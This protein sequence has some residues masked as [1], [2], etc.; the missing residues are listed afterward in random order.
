MKFSYK[1]VCFLSLFVSLNLSAFKIKSHVWVGQQVINDLE[2]DYKLTFIVDG[3]EIKIPIRES[4]RDAILSNKND[5]LMGNIG[6]DAIPDVVVGQ[7]SVHPGS[8]YYW[9]TNDW[10]KYLLDN[11]S[12][13]SEKAFVYGYLGHIASDVFAHTYVNQYAGDVF[14]LTD[15][16]VV[17]KRHFILESFI[18]KYLPP[19]KD[20][21]NNELGKPFEFISMSDENA[22]FIR[23]ELIFND[24]VQYQYWKNSYSRHLAAFYELRKSI[25]SVAEDGIWHDIDVFVTQI[26]AAYFNIDLTDEE[27]SII[28]DAANDVIDFVNNEITDEL[29]VV[30]NNLYEVANKYESMGFNE[31]V[32]TVGKINALENRLLSKKHEIESQVL[33]LGSRLNNQSCSLLGDAIEDP[34]GVLD[35]FD[36]ADPAGVVEFI[37]DN[38]PV[39]SILSGIFNSNDNPPQPYVVWSASGTKQ[40]FEQLIDGYTNFYQWRIETRCGDPQFRQDCEAATEAKRIVDFLTPL[41]SELDSDDYV[42]IEKWSNGWGASRYANGNG[43]LCDA[44]NNIT[45]SL[46]RN[47]LESIQLVEQE[48]LEEKSE[49]V[50]EVASIRQ[51]MLAALDAIRNMENAII[52]LSQMISADVNP[53][54][55]TL[56]GWRD[57]IDFSMKEYVKATSQMMLNTMDSNSSSVSPLI[58]WFDCYHLSIIGVPRSISD[59]NFRSSL[60]TVKSSLENIQEILANASI[61]PGLDDAKRE[62]DELVNN[63]VDEMTAEL[64]NEVSES[65]QD[66]LPTN[67]RELIELLDV[68]VSD[69]VLKHYFTIESAESRS[70]NLLLIDD[71]AQR[72]K[73]EMKITNGTLNPEAFAPLKNSIILAKLALL[74]SNDLVLFADEIGVNN[75]KFYFTDN[76]VSE[77]FENID[78]NH[79]WMPLSPPLPNRVGFP[80]RGEGR[81]YDTDKGFLL[82]KDEFRDEIFRAIFVG[83]LSPGIDYPQMI[84]MPKILPDDYPYKP[85]ETN[86]YPDSDKDGACEVIWLIPI[87]HLLNN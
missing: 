10:T 75:A 86:P 11:A 83:P 82:W 27:A 78:G 44:L 9:K 1:F 79:Q 28:V 14:D 77:S 50:S 57:D 37:I 23:D 61:P 25:D 29:Q 49:L 39:I 16:T 65:V 70:K 66:I 73:S 31:V 87:L 21:Q 8:E 30:L 7:T 47:T 62:L 45:D 69:D 6:P 55:S 63:L 64:K 56:R 52:D 19:F 74:D 58:E 2:D 36:I 3:K 12:S 51:E 13:P 80:Y 59:C 18:D 26:V 22:L 81:S 34:L 76:L 46:L 40:S 35:P 71:V 85:C 43:F 54:Q 32:S 42:T 33:N 5:F 48:F 38:D 17:E 15:E 24:T 84:N 60:E 67:V 68:D 4:L 72:I 41:V 20:Y 53:T